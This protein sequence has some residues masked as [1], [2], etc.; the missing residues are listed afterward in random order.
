[1]KQDKWKRDKERVG[2]VL[3]RH[4]LHITSVKR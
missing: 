2:H 3:K 1:M 4:S